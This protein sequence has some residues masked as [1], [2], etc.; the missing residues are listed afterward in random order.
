MK[1]KRIEAA[2]FIYELLLS[3]KRVQKSFVMAALDISTAT[4]KRVISDI[5]CYLMECEPSKELVF[6]KKDRQYYLSVTKSE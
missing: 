2:L 6:S 1:T 3:H 5:R 4:F